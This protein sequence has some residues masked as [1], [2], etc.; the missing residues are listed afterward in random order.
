MGDS[1]HYYGLHPEAQ[2]RHIISNSMVKILSYGTGVG[3]GGREK[4]ANGSDYAPEVDCRDHHH[5]LGADTLTME[6]N[7]NGPVSSSAYLPF[8]YT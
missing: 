3:L 8:L 2:P 6:W 1:T 5:N 4:K 7:G